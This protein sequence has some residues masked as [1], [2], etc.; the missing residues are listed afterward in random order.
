MHHSS[1]R[2]QRCYTYNADM[3][4]GADNASPDHETVW[5]TDVTK[6]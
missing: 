1:H 3:A 4:V 5:I 2:S 6:S